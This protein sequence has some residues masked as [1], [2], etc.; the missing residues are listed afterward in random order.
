MFEYIGKINIDRLGIDEKLQFQYHLR[1]ALRN[2]ED[3]A[4]QAGVGAL[5]ARVETNLARRGWSGFR[6]DNAPQLRGNNFAYLQRLDFSGLSQEEMAEARKHIAYA[7]GVVG[8]GTMRVA[9]NQIEVALAAAEFAAVANGVA[10]PDVPQ[11]AREEVPGMPGV[12]FGGML[13]AAPQVPQAIV[14]ERTANAT[15]E[16]VVARNIARM[17]RAGI[18]GSISI[19]I[20]LNVD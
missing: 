18:K 15:L 16:D 6:Y 19:N 2:T 5:L 8:E 10:T 3:K 14:I 1:R 7:K 11:V 12:R 9:L 20:T 13:V 17:K 4:I